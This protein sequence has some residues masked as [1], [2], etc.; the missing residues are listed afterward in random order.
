MKYISDVAPDDLAGKRVLVRAG[1]DVPLDKNGNVTDLF[2]VKRAAETL[3]F[4]SERG[5][6]VIV[7]SHIGR[8][9]QETNEPVARALKTEVNVFYVPDLLGAMAHDAMRAMRN[10]EI[11]LLENL[12]RDPREA[13]NDDE[14]A[15]EL[16][17]LGDIYVDDAFSVAHRP[18]AS[19]V[20]IPKH[21]PS[22]AGILMRDEYEV[23]SRARM[24]EHPS[25]AILGGAKFETKSPLIKVLLENYDHLFVAGALA[26]DV[27]KAQGFPVGVSLI[28]KEL[29]DES[30][31]THPHFV[32][33]MDVTVERAD[34]Q[35][36]VK[37]PSSVEEGDKIVDIGPDTV[38]SV[39]PLIASAKFILWNGPTGLYEDGF[40]A[41]T[42]AI[43][44][45]I[46]KSGARAVIG[47]GDT[48]AVIEESG[49]TFSQHVF[50]ST[51]G[52]AMLEFLLNG[53][54]P[55]IDALG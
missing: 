2:R 10:G 11:L 32:A 26:N 16:A 23:L 14:F 17:T 8:E 36:A 4:L 12:R 6:K 25:F 27:L 13:A 43:A 33:P 18:H 35:I 24:P 54:L 45:L 37:A 15:R 38:A 41:Y 5:A 47:G 7:L 46:D 53:T 1:L 49:V 21:L 3:R 9:P 52:G 55:G 48:I 29:P 28:S 42:H 50:L 40:T 34:K 20:G 44:D 31:L 39:A 51:G 22:Y 19:I 30:V